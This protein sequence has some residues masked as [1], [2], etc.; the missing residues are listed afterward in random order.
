[1]WPVVTR[2]RRTL[3]TWSPRAVPRWR[4]RRRC[5]SVARCCRRAPVGSRGGAGQE[6]WR[7]GSPRRL[8]DGGAA[9]RSQRGGVQRRRGCSGGRRRTGR[10]PAT[11]VWKGEERFSSN[12]GN[13]EARRVLTGEGEDSGGAR[14]N[15][16]RGRGLWW[17]E[18]VVQA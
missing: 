9:E 15:L 8:G 11:P 12:S 5:S 2:V 16:T 3:A 13:D 7:R 10:G 14:Q 6:G 17:P 1:V 4:A 18:A